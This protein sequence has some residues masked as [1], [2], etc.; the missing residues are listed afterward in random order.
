[1]APLLE[2]RLHRAG[3]QLAPP[4]QLLI[5]L[6][7]RDAGGESQQRAVVEEDADDVGAAA[8]LAVGA[9]ERFGGADL[10][11]VVGRKA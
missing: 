10:A 3:G 2:K 8:D 7:D 1:M 5:V 9:F 6:L 4:D 11:P